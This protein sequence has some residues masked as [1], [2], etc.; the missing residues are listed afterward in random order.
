[1]DASTQD[2]FIRGLD[3]VGITMAKGDAISTFETSRPAW[4]NQR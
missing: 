3:D 4:L 1:M 2:R